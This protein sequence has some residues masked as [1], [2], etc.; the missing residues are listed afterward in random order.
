MYLRSDWFIQELG[1]LK[2]RIHIK[3]V[4]Y[5]FKWGCVTGNKHIK[6]PVA[7]VIY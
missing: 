3:M 4:K 6:E 5:I 7:V 2:F 1:Y